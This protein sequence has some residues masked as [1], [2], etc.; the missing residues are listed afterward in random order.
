MSAQTFRI[1]DAVLRRA[2]E[3]NNISLENREDEMIL[4]GIRGALPAAPNE[5]LLDYSGHMQFEESHLLQRVNINYYY[6]RC[7]IGQWLPSQR[8][9]AVFL[10]STVPNLKL[11]ERN[12]KRMHQFNCMQ[13]G[14]YDYIKGQHPRSSSGFQQHR[15]LRLNSSIT[16]RRANYTMS[17]GQPVI[18]YGASAAISIGNPGDNIHCARNNPSTTRVR[19]IRGNSYSTSFCLSDYYSSYGCQVI[20]G[21]PPQYI[22]SGQ[23][24]GNWN[25]WDKFI[26]NVYDDIAENQNTFKYLLLNSIDV[27]N[28]AKANASESSLIKVRYGSTGSMVER[29]QRGLAATRSAST[30]NPY[31]SGSIDGDFGRGTGQALIKF[32]K[33]N[34]NGNAY[35]CAGENT[36]RSLGVPI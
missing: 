33:D 9:V 15:A 25:A 20:T 21:C 32:Q 12:R 35:G 19:S 6:P 1:S 26:S 11:V 29:L 10:S 31:Y 8:K 14:F 34:F 18:N 16:L 17:A 2:F 36:F 5:S 24:N 7:L 27:Y 4:F 13:P 3:F 22:P 28:A 30:G 23:S